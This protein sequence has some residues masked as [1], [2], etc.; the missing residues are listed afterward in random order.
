MLQETFQFELRV[1]LDAIHLRSTRAARDP[2]DL[3]VVAVGAR[4][5][6]VQRAVE[7]EAV[8]L[9]VAGHFPA[10]AFCH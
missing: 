9:V 6:R 5:G 8:E 2:D 3:Q 10:E 7:R 1:P 4:R